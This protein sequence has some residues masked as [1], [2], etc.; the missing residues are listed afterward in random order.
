MDVLLDGQYGQSTA[1][2]RRQCARLAALDLERS[3]RAPR[4]DRAFAERCLERWRSDLAALIDPEG[5]TARA[6]QAVVAANPFLRKLSIFRE[7]PVAPPPPTRLAWAEGP[8]E[9]LVPDPPIS[10]AE[11]DEAGWGW[12]RGGLCWDGGAAIDTLT[13]LLKQDPALQGRTAP[14]LWRNLPDDPFTSEFIGFTGFDHRNHSPHARRALQ[15]LTI[16]ARSVAHSIVDFAVLHPVVR[17]TRTTPSCPCSSTASTR[18]AATIDTRTCSATT[19]P[20]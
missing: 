16:L 12:Y 18:S 20:P 9:L 4:G 3:F 13:H 6:F 5:A 10:A 11:E 1:E 2:V 14:H 19:R 7:L 17:P 8:F 15:M